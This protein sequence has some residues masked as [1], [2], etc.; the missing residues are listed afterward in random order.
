MST[1]RP[2]KKQ[3]AVLDFVSNFIAENGYGPSYRE[4]QAGCGYKSLATVATHIDQLVI[5]GHLRKSEN[6]S[7]SLELVDLENGSPTATWLAQRLEK[8][9]EQGLSASD[10]Q[11]IL[12][13]LDLLGVEADRLVKGDAS[14][15][16][17]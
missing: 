3:K 9:E 12:R 6:K 1:I 14:D 10:R 16:T 15:A 8:L 4:I 7:R 11:T 13:A 17:G 2:S 5:R